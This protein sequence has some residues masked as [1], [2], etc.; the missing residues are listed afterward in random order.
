MKLRCLFLVIIL[1]THYI[2]CITLKRSKNRFKAPRSSLVNSLRNNP[3]NLIRF[4]LGFMSV[5][6]EEANNIDNNVDALNYLVN[7]CIKTIEDIY[8]NF[9]ELSLTSISNDV[10]MTKNYFVS[11]FLEFKTSLQDWTSYLW[12]EDDYCQ[13][14]EDENE[15]IDGNIFNSV[16]EYLNVCKQ[17]LNSLQC[18]MYKYLTY[19]EDFIKI[20]KES[21][22]GIY[23]CMSYTEGFKSQK[24]FKGLDYTLIQNYTEIMNGSFNLLVNYLTGGMLGVVDGSFEVAKILFSVYGIYYDSQTKYY[25]RVG[26]TVGNLFKTV[27]ITSGLKKKNKIKKK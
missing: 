25:F 3:T 5:W 24:F 27:K 18:G 9:D 4:T 6:W 13:L 26:Q 14:E 23:N 15:E 21:A 11:K 1:I 2:H 7:N 10:C 19:F 20:T 8:K 22:E 16:G 12:G 17:T